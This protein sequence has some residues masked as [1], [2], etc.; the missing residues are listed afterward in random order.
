MDYL[1]FYHLHEDPFRLTP[2]PHFFYPSPDH[3]DALFSL[4]YVM[5]QR[6]GFSLIVGG[7]GTGKTTIVRT[8]M[9]RWNNKADIALIMT[10][11]LTPEEFLQA[12]L[13]E[14]SIP[15][16]TPNKNDM[17][18]AFRDTLIERSLE[19]RR[20]VIIV[21][22]AQN[23]SDETL[24]ELRL[25]SNMETEKEKLLQIVLVGQTGLMKRL[26][27]TSLEQLSQR[28][29]VKAVLKGLSRSET[30]EYL[31]YRL[32]KA[33]KGT[34]AFSDAALREIH[35]QS[36]GVPRLINLFA[37]RSLM[38]AYVDGAR[39]VEKRHVGHAVKHLSFAAPATR[40]R[41]VPS[42]R[43]ASAFALI[44]TLIFI[45]YAG[46]HVWAKVARGFPAGLTQAFAMTD[47][48][49]NERDTFH[50]GAGPI[51]ALVMNARLRKGASTD[52]EIVGSARTG[53]TFQVLGEQMAEDGRNWFHVKT[54]DGKDGWISA[55]ATTP[56]N[57]PPG[58][59]ASQ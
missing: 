5:E 6:E 28:I 8:F 9:A 36:A 42:P 41:R 37:S 49:P 40:A 35:R 38:A 43:A 48:N 47:K 4:E 53:D 59:S 55:R 16:A 54:D 14:L 1:T 33:G 10:P 22:E 31:N 11:R 21:D 7:P 30:R 52:T 23:M 56:P 29:G 58:P 51:V 13:E 34:A 26:A 12:V 27:L 20:V 45:I 25:L 39:Q 18:K 17:I 46:S 44:A 15:I 24:E 50:S 57:R 2:D 19:G 32:I 3:H